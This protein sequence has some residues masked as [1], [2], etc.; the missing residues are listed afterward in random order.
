MTD[1][2]IIKKPDLQSKQMD[3]FLYD[4]DLRHETVNT[5]SEIWRRP[6]RIL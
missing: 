2:P 5:K 6:A 4:R 1:F 3:M